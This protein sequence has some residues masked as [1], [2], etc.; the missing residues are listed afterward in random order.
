M[1]R[2]VLEAG[3]ELSTYLPPGGLVER[4]YF[5]SH[6]VSENDHETPHLRSRAREHQ[7]F[8]RIDR[9]VNRFGE[10]TSPDMS[11]RAKAPDSGSVNRACESG[12]A[13]G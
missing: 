5:P 4:I 6:D 2:T 11:S 3:G 12:S 13:P 10:V 9:I 8:S 1:M 7:R